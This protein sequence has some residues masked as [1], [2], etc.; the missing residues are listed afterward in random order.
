[1][2]R[3]QTVTHAKEGKAMLAQSKPPA[4]SVL[5]SGEGS[6]TPQGPGVW[7]L[8][9]VRCPQD[10]VLQALPAQERLQLPPAA[11]KRNVK[12]IHFHSTCYV[13]RTRTRTTCE[14]VF[15]K[16]YSSWSTSGN[17]S[18]PLTSSLPQPPHAE[19]P[20]EQ[21]CSWVLGPAFGKMLQP[22]ANH[23]QRCTERAISIR[24]TL[25]KS[26]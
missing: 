16:P 7:A 22:V 10:S 21:K 20:Q 1:M 6:R 23:E 24:Q 14:E 8:P 2:P 26:N 12:K 4:S 13:Q 17:K 9:T 5:T 11:E 18:P 3:T 25:Y 15:I 19:S